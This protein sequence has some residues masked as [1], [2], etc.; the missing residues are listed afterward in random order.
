MLE[1]YGME[2]LCLWHKLYAIETM[3]KICKQAAM[4]GLRLRAL[5]FYMMV[6]TT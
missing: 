3:A 6:H 4:E 1:L 5:G 2:V